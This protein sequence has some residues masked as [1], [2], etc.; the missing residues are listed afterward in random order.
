M[1][2]TNLP[3][4]YADATWVGDRKY[5]INLG[6]GGTYSDSTITDETSYSPTTSGGNYFYGAN[7]A[8]QTNDAI[9]KIVAALGNDINNLKV[10]IANGGTG[11]T[12]ALAALQN[13]GVSDVN[14]TD[15]SAN[16]YSN[17]VS[18]VQSYVDSNLQTRRPFVFHAGWSGVGYGC[19]LAY[20]TLDTTSNQEFKFLILFNQFESAGVKYYCKYP[21]NG[22]FT[23][24]EVGSDRGV[25]LYNGPD[26]NDNITLT[27]SIANYDYV[28]I[29]Y[30]DNGADGEACNFHTKRLYDPSVNRTCL[31]APTISNLGNNVYESILYFSGNWCGKTW[32]KNF[33][34]HND[35]SVYSWAEDFVYIRQIRGYKL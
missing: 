4:N 32:N 7:D 25:I 27:D 5:T 22:V 17:W 3:T 23:W 11:A 8:N 26:K 35:A 13:L 9:N 34:I 20:Q 1:P 2:W 19:G 21:K 10:N 28:D 12:T 18:Q 15:F 14:Q 30:R 33:S 31:T 29:I 6:G 16:S 24:E